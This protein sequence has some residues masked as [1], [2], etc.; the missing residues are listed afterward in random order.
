MTGYVV[1]RALASIPVLFI[2]SLVVFSLLHF[3]PGDPA[4]II[5]GQD[6]TQ[7]EL[8][9]IREHLGLNRPLPVQ[10]GVWLAGILRGDLGQSILSKHR[11]AGLIRERAVPTLFLALFTEVFAIFVGIPLG[12]LAAWKANTKVDRTV[13]IVAT[14]GFSVPVFWLGFILIYSFAVRLPLFPVAGY[15]HPTDGVGPFLHRLILP[16]FATGTIIMALIARMTRASVLE[17]LQEDY[18]RT[19][20]AKG[21]TDSTVLIRHALRNAALPIVT[22]IGLGVAG[23]LGG[24]VITEIVFAIPG[25]GRLLVQAVLARDYPI[26]QGLIL[27]TSAI[28]VVVNLMVDISYAYLDPRI[29][30]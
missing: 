26:I 3:S 18:I 27:V 12:V 28:Y 21:L 8:D 19:A 6:A 10:Y 15:V 14:L 9:G 2:V 29:R 5:A 4:A 1:R 20:R 13:M 23:L 17:V 22:V 30:Y 11:V 16:A 24:V 7:L 25:L